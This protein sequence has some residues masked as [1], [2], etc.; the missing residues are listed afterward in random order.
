MVCNDCLL[1]ILLRIFLNTF[2]QML[3][4]FRI[5]FF[6]EAWW[7]D[8]DVAKS[9]DL[10]GELY[11]YPPFL[12]LRYSFKWINYEFSGKSFHRTTL[13]LLWTVNCWFCGLPDFGVNL[14]SANPLN[15]QTH[16]NSTNCLSVFD[17]FVGL[18]LQGFWSR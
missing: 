5:M 6:I 15:C 13:V 17:H 2:F 7:G 9:N 3:H 16:S 1:Q 4:I 18:V 12:L 11:F 8:N 10:Q 14:L